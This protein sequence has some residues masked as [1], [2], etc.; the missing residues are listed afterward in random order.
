[1]VLVETVKVET[2]VVVETLT[3][4]VQEV[5]AVVVVVVVVETVV[6]VGVVEVL[7]EDLIEPERANKPN[8]GGAPVAFRSRDD[9][10]EP[11]RCSGA[12][13][14]RRTGDQNKWGAALKP[15]TLQP[16]MVSPVSLPEDDMLL[17][18]QGS[19]TLLRHTALITH[20]TAR[21]NGK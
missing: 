17:R 6:L 2:V 5:A 1:M 9:R 21:E 10:H 8:C 3:V 11:M 7:V 12:T 20:C 19:K 13:V 16:F 15:L 4:E 14:E 18:Q